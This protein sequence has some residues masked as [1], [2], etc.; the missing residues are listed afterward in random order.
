[1]QPRS[2]QKEEICLS[3]IGTSDVYS[4][5]LFVHLMGEATNATRPADLLRGA[6]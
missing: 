3:K 6:K 2:A 1:M 4:Y 5:Q